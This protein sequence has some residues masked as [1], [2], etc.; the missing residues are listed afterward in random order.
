MVRRFTQSIEVEIAQIS[1]SPAKKIFQDHQILFST[2][3]LEG[4]R[5]EI[6][7]YV[8]LL[9][10]QSNL[11]WGKRVCQ[12]MNFSMIMVFGPKYKT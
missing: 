3:A 11:G 4:S 5:A 2:L 9:G 12:S 7:V 8:F 10:T 1:L 6:T